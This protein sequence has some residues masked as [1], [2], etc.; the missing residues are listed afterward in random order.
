M[1]RSPLELVALA[2]LLSA[3]TLAQ[4]PSPSQAIALEHQENW[5]QAA[6]VWQA[7]IKQSPR[8]AGALASLGIDFARLQKYPDAAAAY[9]RALEI[10]PNLPGI[11]LNLGLA[12]FKQGRFRSAVAPLRAALAADPASQQAR[13]LLGMSF[14]GAK[15]FAEASKHLELAAKA[16]PDNTELRQVLAQSCLWAKK[17][18]CALEQFQEI[19]RRNPDSAAV[20]ILTGEALDGLG[21]TTEAIV[22]F[23]AAAKFVPPEPNANFGLG[24]LHWKLRQYDDAKR[25][26]ENELALDPGHAQAL[27]YLGDIEMKRENTD[28]ALS[29]LQNAVRL[30]NDIRI[31]YVDIGVIL[32]QKKRY[33]EAL[34]ALRRGE[35]LDPEQ[36]EVHYRL[37]RLYQALGNTQ[38][39]QQEFTKVRHL[40]QKAE[41]DIADKMSGR[42]PVAAI[43]EPPKGPPQ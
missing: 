19:L 26:F 34:L 6:L 29:L 41:D 14:Y 25:A 1:T 8:D 38:A 31:A 37:G 39:A 24:Y 32:T 22:E 28:V 13:A 10:N 15:Q 11:Q 5:E 27:A 12:E 40:H 7:I 16:D 30:R 9:R 36:P 4:A 43:P 2:L 33:S 17:Y 42:A 18:S 23:Q 3:S 21:R 35:N 20:H